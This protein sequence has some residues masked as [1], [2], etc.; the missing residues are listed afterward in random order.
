MVE[1]V[2]AAAHDGDVDI[3]L[4]LHGERI[5]DCRVGNL[6]AA[7]GKAIAQFLRVGCKFQIDIEAALGKEPLG[8]RCE[9]RQV[10]NPREHDDREFYIVRARGVRNGP[11]CDSSRDRGCEQALSRRSSLRLTFG[12]SLGYRKNRVSCRNVT[13]NVD[14]HH[15]R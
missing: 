8:L 10:R 15:G 2:V 4:V 12:A 5:V 13:T 6:V 1:A 3:G 9:D 14:I 7:L 11:Q